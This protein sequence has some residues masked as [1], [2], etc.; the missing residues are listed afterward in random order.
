MSPSLDEEQ[1]GRERLFLNR[2]SVTGQGSFT[3]A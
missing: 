2:S 3:A 1:D